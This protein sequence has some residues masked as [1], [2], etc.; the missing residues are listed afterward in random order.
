MSD[1][2]AIELIYDCKLHFAIDINGFTAKSRTEIFSARIAPVQINYL[3]YPSTMGSSFIDYIVADKILIDD[4]T[5]KNYLE[6]VIFM[7][8]TY[9]PNDNQRPINKNKTSKD[10]HNLP[11]NSF[12]ICCFNNTY[13]ISQDEFEIWINILEKINDGVLWLLD[14]ENQTKKNLIEFTKKNKI[15]SER[16]IF[17]KKINHYQHLERLQHADIFVDTFNYNAH[18]TCSDALWA[19]IPVVTKKGKQFASRVASSLLNAVGLQEMI[20]NTKDEY[21]NLI[22]DLAINRKKIEKLKNKLNHNIKTKPLFNTKQYTSDFEC[23]L[24]KILKNRLKGI[25]DK[26][27]FL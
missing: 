10:D 22:L 16:L 19:G 6:K 23:S 4:Q 24:E 21:E 13:K 27:I 17:A 18:T 11:E 25:E 15:N 12:V 2:N 1:K 7:P 20:C 5:R 8:N 26:D 3:G 9:Q 14:C